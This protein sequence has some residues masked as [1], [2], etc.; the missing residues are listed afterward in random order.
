MKIYPA[1]NC[2]TRFFTAPKSTCPGTVK[3]REIQ[4]KRERLYSVPFF[5]AFF[6][7]MGASFT[8]YPKKISKSRLKIQCFSF[9]MSGEPAHR[10]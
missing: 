7:I 2:S 3:A 5:D 6:A 4:K 9:K 8:M 10:A 1:H